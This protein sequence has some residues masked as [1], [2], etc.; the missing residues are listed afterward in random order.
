MTISTG[1]ASDGGAS[2]HHRFMPSGRRLLGN[3]FV[4]GF[5][6]AYVH[7][8]M[9]PVVAPTGARPPMRKLVMLVLDH[10]KREVDSVERRRA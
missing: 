10:M 6:G 9:R 1:F 3:A 2:K 8:L 4:I 7:V 5:C